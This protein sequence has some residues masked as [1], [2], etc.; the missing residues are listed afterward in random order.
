VR[1]NESTGGTVAPAERRDLGVFWN[2]EPNQ[3]GVL[4][5]VTSEAVFFL[6]L[7]VSYIVYRPQYTPD[8]G[9]TPQQ[10]LNV[11]LTGLFTI[12]LLSSSITMAL[13]TARLSR[14]DVAGATRWLA[15]T[16]LFGAVFL[17]GQGYEYF[18]LFTERLS[19]GSNL[20]TSTFFTLT[21]F[22]GFHVLL[23]L[24]A[25]ATTIAIV[26]LTPGPHAGART[27]ESVSLYWHF[28]DAVWVVIF[29][30]VYLWTLL[31]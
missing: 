29:P 26:R 21:G 9:I 1:P 7:I 2:V 6:T 5:F 3:L 24:I 22:H 12:F 8:R 25:I 17:V 13:A 10:A 27:L 15:T 16:F 31:S 11:P 20:W 18:R 23:G 19:L 14:N 28:V 4:V 30:S